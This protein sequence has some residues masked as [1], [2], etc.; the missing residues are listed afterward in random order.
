MANALYA[1]FKQALLSGAV[2]LT[3]A[4]I[5]V[6]VVDAADYVVDTVNHEFM[7]SVPVAARVATSAAGLASK[8]VTNGTFDAADLTIS[9]VTGDPSE[10]LVLFVNTGSDA[11]A[12]LIAYIDTGSGLPFT[13]NGGD[14]TITWNASGIFSL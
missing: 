2:N 11:T 5:R 3:T 14:A 13:P 8:T 1:K 12:R 10:A 4:D 6:A 9:G 7:S